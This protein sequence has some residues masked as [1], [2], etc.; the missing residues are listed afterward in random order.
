VTW[1]CG[2]KIWL[3]DFVVAGGMGR[4]PWSVDCIP[5][6]AVVPRPDV[7]MVQLASD[8]GG[9]EGIGLSPSVG[10]TERIGGT[11]TGPDGMG[12]EDIGAWVDGDRVG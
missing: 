11:E 9:A 7:A 3:G 5:C 8:G 1:S 4:R 6:V 10:G 12:G 2:T